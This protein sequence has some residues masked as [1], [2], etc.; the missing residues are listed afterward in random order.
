M[1][2]ILGE[3]ADLIIEGLVG[4]VG[5]YFLIAAVS[6]SSEDRWFWITVLS[7]I[8]AAT[9]ALFLRSVISRW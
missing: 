1:R 8:E 9:V 2:K 6:S 4:A 7:L 5:A 3:F